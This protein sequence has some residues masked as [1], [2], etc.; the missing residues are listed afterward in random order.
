MQHCTKKT[1][2]EPSLRVTQSSSS[3]FLSCK[4]VLPSRAFPCICVSP[5]R[6]GT[7]RQRGTVDCQWAAPGQEPACLISSTLSGFLQTN[8]VVRRGSVRR[9]SF[10]CGLETWPY[11]GKVQERKGIEI[12]IIAL[13]LFF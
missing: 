4:Q 6:G 8:S 10:Q 5:S 13:L 9:Q 11:L 1:E 2:E 12:H 7:C 3:G